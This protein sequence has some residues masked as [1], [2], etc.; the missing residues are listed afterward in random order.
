MVYRLT[1]KS[2]YIHVWVGNS[3]L[4]LTNVGLNRLSDGQ[5]AC[6]LADLCQVSTTEAM[7]RAS[8]EVQVNVLLLFKYTNTFTRGSEHTLT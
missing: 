7:R 4:L 2:A 5:L 8:K 1:Q 3:V 6:T